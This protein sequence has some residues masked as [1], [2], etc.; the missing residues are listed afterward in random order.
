MSGNRK[1]IG[2]F[3]LALILALAAQIVWSSIG[4]WANEIV[5]RWLKADSHPEQIGLLIDGTP[6]IQRYSTKYY[7]WEFYTLDQKRIEGNRSKKLR[8][9]YGLLVPPRH[10]AERLDWPAR[11]QTFA[12]KGPLGFWYLIHDGMPN[13]LAYFEGFHPDTN[14]HLGYLGKSGHSETP[15]SSEDRFRVTVEFL[16]AHVTSP[17]ASEPW[18]QMRYVDPLEDTWTIALGAEEAWV[19]NFTRR[20]TRRIWHGSDAIDAGLVVHASPKMPTAPIMVDPNDPRRVIRTRNGLVFFN[21]TFKAEGSLALPEAMREASIRFLVLP[22][23]GYVF[24]AEETGQPARFYWLDKQGTVEKTREV[25]LANPNAKPTTTASWFGIGTIVPSPILMI[26]GI[27]AFG[28]EAGGSH[29][30]PFNDAAAAEFAKAWPTLLV[31]CVGS[32][33]LAIVVHRRQTSLDQGA[34]LG[35]A[36]FVFLFGVAGVAGYWWHRRWPICA[37]CPKCGKVVPRDRDACLACREEFPAPA[38]LSTEIR[39]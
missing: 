29:G 15:P 4:A 34:A 5:S 32:L 19:I 11:I 1:R 16:N 13:G 12:T 22:D 33:A 3:A 2:F 26:G 7:E 31:V 38:A 18:Y 27:A 8:L 20:E 30:I 25:E 24:L 10:L 28:K 39:S 14:Q 35:W 23:E 17:R 6:V 21:K 36:I 9:H 37:A